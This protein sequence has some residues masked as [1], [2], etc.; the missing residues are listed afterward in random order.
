MRDALVAYAFIL[1]WIIGFIVFTGGPIIASFGLSFFRWK[2]IAPPRFHGFTHYIAMFTTDELFR[3]SIWVTFKF[4]LITILLSQL[5]ALMLAL[6]LNQRIRLLG[7][8]RTIFYLPAVVSG[9]AGSG[10]LGVDVSAGVRHYQQPAA[11][12]RVR[13]N[14]LAL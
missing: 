4:A 9:V 1:P 11:P 13:G 10:H 8:W 2:M 12:R 5:L 3:H 6:L 7:L 14:E